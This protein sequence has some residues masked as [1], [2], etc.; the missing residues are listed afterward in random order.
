MAFSASVRLRATKQLAKLNYGANL[1]ER[2]SAL[3]H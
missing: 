3:L 2:A 1:N